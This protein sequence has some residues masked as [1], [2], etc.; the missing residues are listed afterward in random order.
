M[1]GEVGELDPALYHYSPKVHALEQ[2]R[3][4]DKRGALCA[5]ALGQECVADAPAAL[6]CTAVYR[7]ST[8]KYGERGMRYAKIESGHVS[9]N[10]YLQAAALDLGTVIVGAFDD[11]SVRDVLGLD[12]LSAP[13]W[14][15]P[16]GRHR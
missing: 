4:G 1:T 12:A 11:D 13:L 7:R 6:V 2:V 9:Q 16:V 8:I 14:I 3:G 15:M 10:V 5:A